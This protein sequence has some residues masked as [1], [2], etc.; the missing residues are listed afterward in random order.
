MEQITKVPANFIG[1]EF[2]RNRD[3][4]R[5]PFSIRSRHERHPAFFSAFNIDATTEDI[6]TQTRVSHGAT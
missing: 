1:F 4:R 2:R 6:E 3:L 5:S